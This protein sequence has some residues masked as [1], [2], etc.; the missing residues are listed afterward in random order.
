ML[1][2]RAMRYGFEGEVAVGAGVEDVEALAIP[3]KWLIVEGRG[4]A[5]GRR[6]ERGNCASDILRDVGTVA[7]C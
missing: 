5:R 6:K 3:R 1:L 7:S 2:V 4:R